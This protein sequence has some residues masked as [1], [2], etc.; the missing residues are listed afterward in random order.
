MYVVM[1]A[2]VGQR[3]RKGEECRVDGTWIQQRLD[4]RQYE[5]VKLYAGVPYFSED[6][7]WT[8]FECL[9]Y[10][11]VGKEGEK[12]EVQNYGDGFVLVFEGKVWENFLGKVVQRNGHDD[13][14][15]QVDDGASD[16]NPVAVS[17]DEETATLQAQLDMLRGGKKAQLRAEIAAAN[18]AAADHDPPGPS[19]HG[20]NPK[21]T[22]S[23]RTAYAFAQLAQ[24]GLKDVAMELAKRPAHS[25]ATPTAPQVP[26]AAPQ[27]PPDLLFRMMLDRLTG[28]K[29]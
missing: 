14:D 21:E 3:G 17:D 20:F 9:G 10:R 27:V 5:Y 23:A 13:A 19:A 15:E 29:E 25:Q 24:S 7:R 16:W 12:Y 22:M 11:L 28:T 8:M 6:A 1:T 18:A 4:G 26:P 2:P